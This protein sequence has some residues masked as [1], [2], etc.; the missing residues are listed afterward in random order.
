[1]VIGTFNGFP[2]EY[3]ELSETASCKGVVFTL[4][5]AELAIKGANRLGNAKRIEI[6][7]AKI[8]ID[9]LADTLEVF[10]NLIKKAKKCQK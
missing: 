2:V 4:S 10:N 3:D 8:R 9:C 1:M 7:G 6:T 5:Q